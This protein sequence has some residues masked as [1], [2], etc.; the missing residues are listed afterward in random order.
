MNNS[1]F[2]DTYGVNTVEIL[3][4]DASNNVLRRIQVDA[5]GNLVTSGGGGTSGGTSAVPFFVKITDDGTDISPVETA[6]DWNA[7]PALDPT[8][9]A[10]TVNSRAHQLWPITGSRA[11]VSGDG[12]FYGQLMNDL[13]DLVTSLGSI[14]SS[15]GSTQIA[16]GNGVVGAGVQRVA[17]ASNNTAFSVNATLT[18]ETTKVIGTVNQGTTPWA[19]SDNAGSLTVDAPVG[20]PVYVTPTPSVGGGASYY[21]NT[22]LSSTK[23]QISSAA[24]TVTGWAVHNPAAATTYIQIWDLASASVTVGTTAPSWTLVLPAGATAN[25]F[26]TGGVKHATGFTVAAT[27][28]ATGS[29]APATAA[30]VSFFYK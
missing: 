14:T 11:G 20:A 7:L 3:G 9:K 26:D 4:Q 28:T 27:T 10:L 23:Q 5:S 13:G 12:T 16:T 17:I 29:T 19:I 8:L 2:D 30:V 25:M 18:A 15:A 22:A 24:C 1:S 6:S 21:S